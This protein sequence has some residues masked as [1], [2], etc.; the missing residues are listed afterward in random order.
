MVNLTILVYFVSYLY[1]FA[2]FISL[3]TIDRDLPE[4]ANSIRLLGLTF[5]LSARR[6][7]AAA[8]A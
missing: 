8:G 1:L 4:D 3:R 6:R 2:A 5:S 7:G